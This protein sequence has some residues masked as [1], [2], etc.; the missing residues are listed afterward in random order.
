ME[1]GSVTLRRIGFFCFP[2][3]HSTHTVCIECLIGKVA[4]FYLNP[5]GNKTKQ[6]IGNIFSWKIYFTNW[7]RIRTRKVCVIALANLPPPAA[8]LMPRIILFNSSNQD[9][10]SQ[11]SSQFPTSPLQ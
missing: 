10:T 1:L 9:S 11:K 3:K 8:G 7:D 2:I 5:N 6:K 4:V